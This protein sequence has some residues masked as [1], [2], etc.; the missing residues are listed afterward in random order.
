MT[1]TDPKTLTPSLISRVYRVCGGASRLY[2]GSDRRVYLGPPDAAQASFCGVIPADE[3][4]SKDAAC[5]AAN[6]H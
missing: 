3:P 6:C 1:I 2:V 5:R 4:I